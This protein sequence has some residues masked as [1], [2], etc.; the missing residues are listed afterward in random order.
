MFK[1]ESSH[2]DTKDL[3][4]GLKFS[5]SRYASSKCRLEKA[6]S[7]FRSAKKYFK[8]KDY[9]AMLHYMR[10]SMCNACSALLDLVQEEEEQY[11]NVMYRFESCYIETGLFNKHNFVFLIKIAVLT[12]KIVRGDFFIMPKERFNTDLTRVA[13]FLEDSEEILSNYYTCADRE[14]ENSKGGNDHERI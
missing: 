9:I 13:I 8:Q 3:F 12:E 11:M 4:S 5:E 1:N 2:L 14:I 6:K 10:C 7:Y